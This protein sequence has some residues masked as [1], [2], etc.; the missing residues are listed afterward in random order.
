MAKFKTG[1]LPNISG[2]M[3]GTSFSSTPYGNVMRLKPQPINTWSKIKQ[4]AIGKNVSVAKIWAK[5]TP[6]QIE[7]WT[8]FAKD[9][10]ISFIRIPQSLN[11]SLLTTLQAQA[12]FEQHLSLNPSISL[13]ITN[14]E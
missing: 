8:E 6:A 12:I 1:I 2:S 7:A 4:N 13:R 14:N 10:P 5:C 3:G 11:D 9:N